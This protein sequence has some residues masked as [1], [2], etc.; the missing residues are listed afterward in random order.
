MITSK[1]E[2]NTKNLPTLTGSTSENTNTSLGTR[3][4]PNKAAFKENLDE[5]KIHLSASKDIDLEQCIEKYLPTKTR[6][7]TLN[8]EWRIT[9]SIGNL[10]F[11]G[12]LEEDPNFYLLRFITEKL[13]Y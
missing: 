4:T 7:V 3:S 5:I 9:E 13:P 8:N 1:S 12:L 2:E 6:T 11:P 10:D